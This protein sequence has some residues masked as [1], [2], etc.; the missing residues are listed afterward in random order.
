MLV[1]AYV[2]PAR[3]LDLVDVADAIA[4][5]TVVS[6]EGDFATMKVERW[7]KGSHGSTVRYRARRSFRCDTSDAVVGERKLMF[8]ETE[9]DGGLGIAWHGRGRRDPAE[10]ELR[11]V[12][13]LL[14]RAST[15]SVFRFETDVLPASLLHCESRNRWFYEGCHV[16]PRAGRDVQPPATGEELL[17]TFEAGSLTCFRV[18]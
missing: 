2:A 13:R 3:L 14:A 18:P 6:C 12:E 16:L 5:G 7:L 15:P 10:D 1:L 17:C 8:F 11:D 4:I 9:R